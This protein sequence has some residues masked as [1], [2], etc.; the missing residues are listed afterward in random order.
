MGKSTKVSKSKK[1]AKRTFS[2][3]KIAILLVCGLLLFSVCLVWGYKTVRY[4][5]A[6]ELIKQIRQ[7]PIYTY[8]SDNLKIV[9]RSEDYG[10]KDWKGVINEPR[11]YVD[12]S[13]LSND[14]DL[15]INELSKILTSFSWQKKETSYSDNPSFT[16]Q[17][18]NDALVLKIFPSELKGYS[19]YISITG[20]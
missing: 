17:V 3:L 11:V 10:G 8:E 14:K 9:S 6:P 16:K 1:G 18:T 15:C 12:F 5:S 20:E 7:E 4:H 19:C 2:S 13:Q